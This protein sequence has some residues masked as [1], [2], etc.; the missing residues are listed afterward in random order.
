MMHLAELLSMDEA[1]TLQ[2]R[3][4]AED[5]DKP[6]FVRI[7]SETNGIA[8][9][10]ICMSGRVLT[11]YASPYQTSFDADAVEAVIKGGLLVV[12]RELARSMEQRL[13]DLNIDR[14]S[15]H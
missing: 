14:N 6:T 15:V 10:C 8:V 9:I 1:S 4:D 13:T 12:Q 7:D 2:K 3:I 11:W 5:P